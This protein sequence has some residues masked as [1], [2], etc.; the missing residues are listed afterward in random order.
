[1]IPK[2]MTNSVRAALVEAL[3]PFG[4]LRPSSARAEDAPESV[5]PD[6]EVIAPGFVFAPQQ[7]QG[8]RGKGGGNA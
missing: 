5:V 1:M 8:A 2:F 4:W 6:L 7:P 3:R